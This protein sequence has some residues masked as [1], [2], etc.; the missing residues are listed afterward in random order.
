MTSHHLL[1]TMKHGSM[2]KELNVNTN[3]G[4]TKTMPTVNLSDNK[5]LWFNCN[6]QS[7]NTSTQQLLS[8]PNTREQNYRTESN[9]FNHNNHSLYHMKIY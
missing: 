9:G 8:T 4:S 1:P 5:M 7:P 6:A 2:K 3:S